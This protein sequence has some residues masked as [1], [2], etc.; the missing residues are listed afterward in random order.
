MNIKRNAVSISLLILAACSSEKASTDSVT[1]SAPAAVETTAPA[2]PPEAADKKFVLY[3]GRNEK[4]I[5][6]LLE[7]FTKETGIAVEARFGE[8]A[9]LAATLLE[10]GA[11]TPAD[12]FF[13]QDAAGLGAV[14][15]G[16]L[17]QTLPAELVKKVP[18][19]FAAPDAKWIGVSGRARTIV[20]DPSK[21][22]PEQLP[23]SLEELGAPKF[24]GKFGIAPL[25]ASF[26]S[27]MS[28]FHALHGAE[29]LDRLL[30]AIAMNEPRRYPKNG[31]IVDAVAS[32]EIEWGLVNHYYVWEAKKSRPTLKVANFFLP[33]GDA[34][35]YVNV[36]G[37]ALLGNDPDAAAF[38]EYLLAESAQRYFAEKTF[39]YPLVA[40]VASPVALQPLDELRTPDIDFGRV[41]DALPATL[42]KIT[43]S[44]L[45]KQ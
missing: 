11:G 23:Q 33:K 6:P 9:E 28:A 32:G 26:Q 29:A 44:G 4:L 35:S 22:K 17:A 42:A 39:E 14:A 25:N 2:K 10:E 20:Y 15:K 30:K 16:G 13:S 40:G 5:K 12:V 24:K 27:Q 38:V 8:S 19:R 36:A 1:N 45:S 43:E 18:A 34:S 41:A 31:A 7:Q 21:I 37:V 3:S